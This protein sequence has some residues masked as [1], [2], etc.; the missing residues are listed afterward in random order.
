MLKTVLRKIW[1]YLKDW[2]NLLTHTL[3]GLGILAIAFYMPVKPIYRIV[4]LILVV[5]FNIIRMRRHNS[6]K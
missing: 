6:N 5:A 4:F 1:A 2:K 3:V